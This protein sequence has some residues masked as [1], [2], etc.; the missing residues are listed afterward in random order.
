MTIENDN[1]TEY[2]NLWRK[3]IIAGNNDS[4][5]AFLVDG[6]K[7][8]EMM[9][10]EETIRSWLDEYDGELKSRQKMTRNYISDYLMLSQNNNKILWWR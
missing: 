4:Y 3:F 7:Q 9:Y 8:I 10:D 5:T 2:I 1:K 6:M